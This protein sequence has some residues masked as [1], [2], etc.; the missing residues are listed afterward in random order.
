MSSGVDNDAARGEL[1]A[2]VYA[3]SHDLRAPLRSIT[4]FNQLLQEH[5]GEQLDDQSLHCLA[6]IQEGVARMSNLI[7]ALLQLSRVN[8][9]DLTRRDVDLSELARELSTALQAR[10][11]LRKLTVRIEPQMRINADTRLARQLL[12]MLLDNAYKFSTG[13]PET[14]I[15]IGRAADKEPSTYFVRDNGI[16]FNNAYAAKLG[17]PFQRIHTDPQFTGVGIGL[18]I[19]HR[20]VARHGGELWGEG[21]LDQGAT[22]Y[23]TLPNS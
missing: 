15:E 1:D 20:I 7:D 6:R 13:R 9:A 4:A 18:A 17:R 16:G 3:I 23:F 10:D 19:A 14:E 2:L 22:F 11:P 8:R 5:A 21:G 12:D